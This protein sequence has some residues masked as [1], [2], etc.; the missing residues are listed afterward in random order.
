MRN[1]LYFTAYGCVALLICCNMWVFWVEANFL[2][3]NSNLA[4]QRGTLRTPSPVF[5][6]RQLPYSSSSFA[7][8]MHSLSL[9]GISLYYASKATREG[10]GEEGDSH[11]PH[12]CPRCTA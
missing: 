11:R 6:A 3:A 9:L 4:R 5:G 7:P 10:L 8:F 12:V 1:S 2:E